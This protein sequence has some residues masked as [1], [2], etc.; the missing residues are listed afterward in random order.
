MAQQANLT[1]ELDKVKD[2]CKFR[3]NGVLFSLK[4]A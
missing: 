1:L 4:T 3:Y 2:L